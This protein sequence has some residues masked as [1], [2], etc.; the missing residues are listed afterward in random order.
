MSEKISE[1]ILNI[2][3]KAKEASYILARLPTD[4]KNKALYNMADALEKNAEEILE[5]NKKDVEASR[6]KGVREALLDRLILT[7]SRISK[8]AQCLREVA[9]LPDP[10]GEIVKTWIRP[11]GLIIG[12]MR[13]PLGVVAV[14]YESRPDVTSD[15][16][17]ICLKSGNA[18]ILRGGSDAI[19]SNITIGKILNEAAVESGIPDGTIQVVPITER[20]AAL[21]LMKMREYVDVLIPRGG[22]GLIRAVI[23]NAKV[24]VIETG[25]GNCH[26]Y[27]ESDADLDKAIDIII[28]AKC[29]RPGTCN[30]AEKLLVHRDIAKKFLPRIINEL[31]NHGVEIRGCE[32][33]R[34]IVPD[35]KPATEEDWYTEYLDLVIGVK[36]VSGLDEAIAHINKYGTKHSDAILTSDFNKAL[37]FIRDV[38]S[39]AVYWNASTRFTDGNQYGLGA[40][41][42]I[43]TQKLHARGP[44]S[45][46]HLTS[47][48]YFILGRGHIRE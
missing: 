1:L 30:A 19:N 29:Q 24:P 45:V 33:T 8:M 25:T 37:R 11:N 14:I 20:S 34:K 22:A 4:T 2:C 12:Q 18:V 15:A 36:I 43:S 21:E 6:A 41:I 31:R 9:E 16:A 7:K 40:E 39:A 28:N 23:E 35:V 38:D 13:V 10:V 46:Q 26:I 48:K 32:E 47:I 42:G 44:M 5:A 17:G 3:K 27:V